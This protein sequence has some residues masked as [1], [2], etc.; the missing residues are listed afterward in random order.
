MRLA[1]PS[2]GADH[3]FKMN[4]HSDVKQAIRCTRLVRQHW[5]RRSRLFLYLD[6]NAHRPDD[7]QAL[8]HYCDHVHVSAYEPN[9]CQ[10]ILNAFNYLMH[11]ASAQKVGVASF[12][13]ADLIPMDRAAFY[14]FLGR[15]RESGK[16]LT[17]TPMWQGRKQIDFCN[18]HFQVQRAIERKLF[19]VVRL[20]LPPD[21]DYNENQ[22]CSSFDLTCPGWL[23]E[24]YI[25]W[26]IVMPA[27]WKVGVTPPAEPEVPALLRRMEGMIS[28]KCLATKPEGRAFYVN[29]IGHSL[30]G[31]FIFHNYVPESTV[32]HT[33]DEW[34]WASYESLARLD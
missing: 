11:Y 29:K 15:F 21:Q 23:D 14:Q 20:P 5:S 34:F 6:G 17:M 10:S 12:L 8:S 4:C 22:F 32:I 7:L 26:A 19:P 28:L 30:H 18:L 25:M 2:Q 31:H 16:M 33:N 9:K 1:H 3:A 27:S 13:H 24:A